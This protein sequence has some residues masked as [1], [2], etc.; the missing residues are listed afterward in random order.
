MQDLQVRNDI[1]CLERYDLSWFERV[2]KKANILY[3]LHYVK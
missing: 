1:L 2:K 3:I